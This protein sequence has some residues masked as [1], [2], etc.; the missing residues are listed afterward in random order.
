MILTLFTYKKQMY[1]FNKKNYETFLV[2]KTHL[3]SEST[4]TKF[5]L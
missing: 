5:V 4:T 3:P 2:Y 1:Y